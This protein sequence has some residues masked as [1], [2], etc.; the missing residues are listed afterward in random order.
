M[1]IIWQKA[2]LFHMSRVYRSQY[3]WSLFLRS[4]FQ[5]CHKNSEQTS[6]KTLINSLYNKLGYH[7]SPHISPKA[8][9]VN[10]IAIPH[11][12]SHGLQPID[13]YFLDHWIHIFTCSEIAKFIQNINPSTQAFHCIRIVRLSLSA[14]SKLVS[15]HNLYLMIEERIVPHL[16][17][18]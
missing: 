1:S 14:C 8:A 6:I 16:E 10:I 7:I 18:N 9:T 3:F 13:V 17:I 11:H 15:Y 2:C 5:W 4:C 12:F